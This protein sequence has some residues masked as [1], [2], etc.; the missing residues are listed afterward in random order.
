MGLGLG[1]ASAL[2]GVVQRG[3]TRHPSDRVDPLAVALYD[4]PIL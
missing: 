1:V 4:P 3:S 2:V